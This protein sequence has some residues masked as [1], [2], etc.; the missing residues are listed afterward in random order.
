MLEPLAEQFAAD[1]ASKVMTFVQ[2]SVRGE[3]D[4]LLGRAVGR[5]LRRKGA[6]A[7][8]AL[9]RHTPPLDALKRDYCAL[10]LRA[11]DGNIHAT[12][13]RLEVPYSSLRADLV[14]WGIVVPRRRRRGR[15]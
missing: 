2:L 11:C 12:S 1:V 3:V 6:G 5:S 10:V 15:R 9:A 4:T 8:K 7:A 13:R 14:R